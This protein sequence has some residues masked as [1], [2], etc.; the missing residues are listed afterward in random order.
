MAINGNSTRVK[1]ELRQRLEGA[2]ADF[3]RMLDSIDDSQWGLPSANSKWSIGA[4]F[5]HCGVGL[6]TIPLRMKSAREG[7]PKQW[8][9]KFVFDFVNTTL[10]RKLG[11][12]HDRNSVRRYF[13]EQFAAAVAC[14]DDVNDSEW[15]LVSRT[16][17]QRWTVRELF[18]YQPVHIAEHLQNI[19]AVL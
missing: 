12:Q 11:R 3:Y 18:A 6:G 15:D 5:A 4:T 13:D 14:L 10:T 16:Y 7:K 8:M 9:P 17:I 1:D 2:R 19:K